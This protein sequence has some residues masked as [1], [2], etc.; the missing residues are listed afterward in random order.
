[1]PKIDGVA[2]GSAAFGGLFIYAG[3]K[4]ISVPAAMRSL[5]TGKSPAGLPQTQ[6]ITGT[7]AGG[8][9]G[10]GG[11]PAGNVPAGQGEQSYFSA[12]LRDLGAPASTANLQ[13]MYRW[14]KKEE[15]SFPPPN[16]WNPLNIKNPQTG[17]FAQYPS[18]RA[19][20]FSSAAFMINNHYTAIVSSLR[21]GNGI[22]D[23]PE[24]A[25]ELLAWSGGGYSSVNSGGG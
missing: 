23:S 19:G 15:P 12:L 25:R 13:A 9:G 14:A 5:I 18:P 7:A 4:G 20:A 24:V 2:L 17:S 21:T 10:G 6:P 11:G 22:V 16:A 1:M 8:A 3:V